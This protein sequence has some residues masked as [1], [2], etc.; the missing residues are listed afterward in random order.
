MGAG[1]ENQPITIDLEVSDFLS[2]LGILIHMTYSPSGS[3]G[4]SHRTLEA[5]HELGYI[6]GI[7]LRKSKFTPESWT[8]SFYQNLSE[9]KP[10]MVTGGGHAFICD[11]YSMD[12]LFHFNLGWD[13]YAD[14]Y[15]P[16]SGVM[17]LPVNEAFVELE[18]VS[19]PVPPKRIAQ[20]VSEGMSSVTWV[21]SP[22]QHHF[23][24][25]GPL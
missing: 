9:Y 19:W 25:T 12:G 3:S 18:P 13:G 22:D 8:E 10:I 17:N 1:R 5:F 6:N 20:F 11:G 24:R 2:D 21:Y 7:I 4:N 15:Y 23:F 16:L 14:G